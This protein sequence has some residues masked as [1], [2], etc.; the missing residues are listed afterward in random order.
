MDRLSRRCFLIGLGAV[1]AA[2][3]IVQASSLMPVKVFELAPAMANIQYQV[4]ENGIWR[5]IAGAASFDP[6]AA[7]QHI[8]L[9]AP[10]HPT[11]GRQRPHR[12]LTNDAGLTIVRV[13]ISE[14]SP[15]VVVGKDFNPVTMFRG[16]PVE[17]DD[18]G[19]LERGLEI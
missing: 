19:F 13:A 12:F 2:P 15:L 5:T 4:Q 16:L 3:A 8:M 11:L 18:D 7:M 10:A 14:K 17:L 1:L 6:V 9:E